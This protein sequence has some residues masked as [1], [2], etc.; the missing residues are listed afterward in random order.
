MAISYANH[1]LSVGN[2]G[3]TVITKYNAFIDDSEARAQEV[4]NAREGAGTLVLNLANYVKYTLTAP[5]AGNALYKCTGMLDGD[6]GSQDYCTVAQANAIAATSGDTTIETVNV[7]NLNPNDIVVVNSS[8][9]A[10]TG[11]PTTYIN[12]IATSVANGNY[13]MNLSTGSKVT[14][15]PDN[16]SIGTVISFAD[17]SGDAG[18]N[19]GG[20]PR[21]P[22]LTINPSDNPPDARYI[23]GRGEN[24]ALIIDDYPYCSF[25]L[26]Y[27]GIPTFGWTLAR[28]QR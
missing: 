14:D 28:F 11:R 12:V 25:D 7:G 5:I 10:F 6:P 26:V 27:T 24:E 3:S 15:L 4:E 16:P 8:G 13:D 18:I 20:P 9:N 19:G 2:P 1:R 22:N 23:M 17:L 21:T